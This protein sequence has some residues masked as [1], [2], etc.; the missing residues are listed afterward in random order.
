MRRQT[1]VPIGVI[2]GI[3]T[4]VVYSI[5]AVLIYLFTGGRAFVEIGASLPMTVLVYFGGGILGGAIVGSLLPFT[6]RRIGSVFV[7]VV[8]GI[9]VAAG[10][11]WLLEGPI[12]G[13]GQ[14]EWETVFFLAAFL[15]GG[16]GFFLWTPPKR[17]SVST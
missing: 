11:V 4:A 15:G 17:D 10:V 5:V 9:P 14:I 1:N 2:I 6:E 16:G 3:I 8:G 12:I 7:G 13:W